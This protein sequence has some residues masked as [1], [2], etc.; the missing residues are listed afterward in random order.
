MLLCADYDC[1]APHVFGATCSFV[2]EM[3]VYLNQIYITPFALLR[4]LVK[5]EGVGALYKGTAPVMLRA[6]PA[7]AAC[8]FGVDIAKSIF[9]SLEL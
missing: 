5:E 2:W 3:V 8:F 7:N 9:R 4:T 1:Y 6:F